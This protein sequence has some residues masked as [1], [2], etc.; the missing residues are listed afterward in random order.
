MET[1]SHSS[2]SKHSP[3]AEGGDRGGE[4][5]VAARLASISLGGGVMDYY[6]DF[7]THIATDY[8]QQALSVDPNTWQVHQWSVYLCSILQLKLH[9]VSKVAISFNG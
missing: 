7:L 2:A 9:R 8:A 6:A 1:G 5:T 3:G 4:A